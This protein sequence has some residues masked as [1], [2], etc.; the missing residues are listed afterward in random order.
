MYAKF[1][2]KL[3]NMAAAML[4]SILSL[5]LKER[6]VMTITFAQTAPVSSVKIDAEDIKA[7]VTEM[8]G[9]IDYLVANPAGA[10]ALPQIIKS[11]LD[12]Y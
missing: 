5:I 2:L 6:Y 11:I 10:A 8:K 9:I 12:S 3:I 1:K 7:I 4:L